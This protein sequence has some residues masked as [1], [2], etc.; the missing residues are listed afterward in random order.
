MSI[1]R[2]RIRYYKSRKYPFA[3]DCPTSKEERETEQ[4]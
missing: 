3:K 2:D 4:I 1:N